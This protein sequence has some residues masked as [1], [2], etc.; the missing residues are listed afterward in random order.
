MMKKLIKNHLKN[1][2]IQE[3]MTLKFYGIRQLLVMI[4][5]ILTTQLIN[6]LSEL[7]EQDQKALIPVTTI[8]MR[9]PISSMFL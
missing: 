1:L 9:L 5:P 6:K 2:L 8:K 4:K 3:I 7:L